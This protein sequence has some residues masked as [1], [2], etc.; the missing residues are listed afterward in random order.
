MKVDSDPLPVG[1]NFAEPVSFEINMVN[2][3]GPNTHTIST[4]VLEKFDKHQRDIYPRKASLCWIFFTERNRK[5][6]T[7]LYVLDA[8]LFS[9]KVL[10]PIMRVQDS[11]SILT[12][13]L[14]D[15]GRIGN[16]SMLT[17]KK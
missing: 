7:L 3:S 16:I 17:W 13:Y 15:I 11:K 5:E 9:T 14:P 8:V 2:V 1:V 12:S 4:Y 10:L 6:E